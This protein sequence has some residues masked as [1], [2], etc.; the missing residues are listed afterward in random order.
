M[1]RLLISL[2]R[3]KNAYVERYAR[4]GTAKKMR[5]ARK[6]GEEIV[7]NLDGEMIAA[8]GDWEVEIRPGSVNFVVPRGVRLP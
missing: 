1:L 8:S 4:V 2:L 7:A 5:V 6:Y 3:Q